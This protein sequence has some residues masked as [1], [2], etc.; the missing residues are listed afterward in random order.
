MLQIITLPNGHHSTFSFTSRSFLFFKSSSSLTLFFCATQSH[1][2]FSNREAVSFFVFFSFFLFFFLISP[3]VSLYP[4]HHSW[5]SSILFQVFHSLCPGHPV[6]FHS[7][8]VDILSS[9]Q[10]RV[11][12]LSTKLMIFLEG[13][14]AS[15]LPGFSLFLAY[16]ECTSHKQKILIISLL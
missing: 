7:M 10:H 6:I 14:H 5:L 8:K 11:M 2:V 3:P 16:L 9:N 13:F 12:V 15:C 4:C 1:L